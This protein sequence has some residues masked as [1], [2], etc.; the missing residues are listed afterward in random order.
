MLTRRATPTT[1]TLAIFTVCVTVTCF[2]AARTWTD[3]T[4]KYRVEAEFVRFEDSKVVLKTSDGRVV[5]VLANRLSDADQQ[6]VRNELQRRR[7]NPRNS[8]AG[9][10][11]GATSSA[12]SSSTDWPQWRGVR[13]DGISTETGLNNDWDSNP[14]RLVW[15]ADGLGGGMS[16]LVIWKDCIYTLGKSGET[17]LI[18]LNRNDGSRKWATPITG[19]KD[20]TSTPTVDPE[21]GLVFGLTNDGDLICVDAD[22][23]EQWRTNFP[24]DFRGR[25]MSEWGYS[26]SPLVDGD[27]LIVTPG[28]DRA[29]L[30]AL[31]KRTGEVIW[32]TV[33]N[34][35]RG[36]GYSTPVISQ[37]GGVKQYIT[38]V[39][40]GLIGVDAER[41][42]LLWHYDRIAN[43]TANVPTPIVK[44]DYVFT[45]TGYGDG[46][47]AL[48]RLGKAGRGVSFQ[49]VYYKSNNQL[50]NHHGGMVMIGDY[51]YMGHGH[52]NGFPVCVEW[53]TGRLA[54]GPGRGPGSKSAAIVAADGHLYFR[55]ED[56]TMALIEAT[57]SRYNLKGSFRIASRHGSSW[58]H[59]VI[60]DKKLYLRDQHQLH[61]YDLSSQ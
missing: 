49:E 40:S 10:S 52:N 4:G 32:T 21:T 28:G 12:Q 27:R 57:P 42:T 22:G 24:K 8:P 7:S 45:S 19:G 61:C 1:L 54:W 18:C 56:A 41:G 53:K 2:A 31:N 5:A 51:I 43:S 60:S 11:S 46:G 34:G 58:P 33:A 6:W 30:A 15:S 38:L 14:P 47:S 35:S 39:G 3:R 23:R 48:L 44:D 26:E 55:Y 17:Q 37:A 25:M 13:Q 50:Q 29:V 59:P 16:S 9:G 20:P 36:A